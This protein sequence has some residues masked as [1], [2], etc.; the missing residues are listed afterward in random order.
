MA[1]S[2]YD[3]LVAAV[4]RACARSNSSFVA[5]IPDMVSMAEDRI[6]NGFGEPGEPLYSPPLRARVMEATGTITLVDA[7]GTLPDDYLSMRKIIRSGDQRGLTYLTPERAD[8]ELA[9]TSVAATPV[10]YTIAGN[11][12]SVVPSWDGDL[13]AL[14]Y[15]RF[16]PISV[17]NKTGTLLTAHG[18]LYFE[19]VLIE[20]FAWQQADEQTIGHAAKFRGMVQGVNKGDIDLRYSGPLRARVRAF[21]P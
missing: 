2:D 14:Y 21:I 17:A 18:N 5:A 3:T 12:I 1:F 4:Q 19:A 9:A 13:T 6:Y 8:V 10:W 7:K 11:E 20:A 16:D 15:R